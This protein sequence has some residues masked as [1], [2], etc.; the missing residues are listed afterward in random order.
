MHRGRTSGGESPSPHPACRD[1]CKVRQSIY[2]T[3]S[4]NPKEIEETSTPAHAMAIR[5]GPH[6]WNYKATFIDREDYTRVEKEYSR[7]KVLGGS[8]S[9]NYY[10]WLRG[11]AGTFD[12]WKEYGGDEWSWENARE[13]FDKPAT[14]HDDKNLFPPNLVD[15]GRGP[16]DIAHP[17]PL[18]EIRE[19]RSA[20]EKA[21]VSHGQELSVDVYHGTQKVSLV[22]VQVDIRGYSKQ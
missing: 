10:T 21:W 13:Y 5:H 6:D 1:G 19:W 12:E 7:G 9:I 3:D 2:E 14:F 8:T 11:S 17:A 4:S 16:I 22:M 18:S 15:S 20:L